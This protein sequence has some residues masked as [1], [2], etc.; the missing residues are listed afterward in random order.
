MEEVKENFRLFFCVN[1]GGRKQESFLFNQ[2]ICLSIPPSPN[3]R[4]P[5]SV[6]TRP[7][8][9]QNTRHREHKRLEAKNSSSKEF[10]YQKRALPAY[11]KLQR[12][13]ILPLKYLMLL[14]FKWAISI[15]FCSQC[16]QYLLHQFTLMH[17]MHLLI[18]YVPVI[19]SSK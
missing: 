11:K 3:N 16:I 7:L 9:G 17:S 2:I 4:P 6:W 13:G 12:I 1:G 5:P 8:S 15:L 18:L 10:I 19:K 14:G